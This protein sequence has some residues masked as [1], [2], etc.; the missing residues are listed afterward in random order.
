[1]LIARSRNYTGGIGLFSG[2]SDLSKTTEVSI[3]IM[4]YAEKIK[5][6]SWGIRRGYGWG[7]GEEAVSVWDVCV[8]RDQEDGLVLQ[9]L[10]SC[11]GVPGPAKPVSG[12]LASHNRRA[13]QRW[14]ARTVGRLLWSPFTLLWR[15]G[16]RLSCPLFGPCLWRQWGVLLF[17]SDSVIDMCRK[18]P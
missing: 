15:T 6:A 17:S 13:Y 5:Y 18:R 14:G 9:V 4:T 10:A 3:K 11:D 8:G 7:K 16:S 2:M 1:M 12:S